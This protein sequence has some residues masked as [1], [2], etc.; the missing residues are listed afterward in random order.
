MDYT[1]P[2]FTVGS[3]SSEQYRDGWERTFGKRTVEA[4]AGPSLAV[5]TV[6]DDADD[7]SAAASTLPELPA[8]WRERLEA[9]WRD[10]AMQATTIQRQRGPAS[11]GAAAGM[12]RCAEALKDALQGHRE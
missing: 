3:L 6:T 8:A 12:L 4:A 11:T 10:W 5:R 2:S 9:M 7:T 1:K